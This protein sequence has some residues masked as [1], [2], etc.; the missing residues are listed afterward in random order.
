MN[1]KPIRRC[2]KCGFEKSD[3]IL[4]ARDGKFLGENI[5]SWVEA[6]AMLEE[7]FGKG[8]IIKLV[9]LSMDGK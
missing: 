3:I 1:R 5:S 2:P 6:K 4:D 7:K 8:S 9:S